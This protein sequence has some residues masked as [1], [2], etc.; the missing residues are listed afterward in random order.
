MVRAYVEKLL[1]AG[2]GRPIAPD[3]DGDY[4]LPGEGDFYVRVLDETLAPVPLVQVFALAVKGVDATP[5]LLEDLNPLN[6]GVA[7]ARIFWVKDQVLVETEIVADALEPVALATACNT[8]GGVAATHGPRL[9]L[10]HGGETAFGDLRP[11]QVPQL[12]PAGYL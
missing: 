8:V 3:G 9:K 12:G 2:F 10:A 5:A 4:R 1:A 7:F 11:E 6:A